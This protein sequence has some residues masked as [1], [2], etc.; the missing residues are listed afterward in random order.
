MTEYK[1]VV[2]GAGGVG[3]SAVSHW[4]EGSRGELIIMDFSHFFS[5]PAYDTINSE[6]LCWWWAFCLFL[7]EKL[8]ILS[9]ISA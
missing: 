3:K 9:W 8:C 4:S 2:V 7:F 6:S 1:L 5:I